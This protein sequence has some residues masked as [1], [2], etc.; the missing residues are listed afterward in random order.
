MVSLLLLTRFAARNER[1]SYIP[2]AILSAVAIAMLG[3]FVVG[4]QPSPVPSG[5]QRNPLVAFTQSVFSEN[6]SAS[7]ERLASK[8]EPDLHKEWPFGKVAG[9]ER[10]EGPST[11][12]RNVIVFAY[13][14]TPAKQSQGFG[15]VMPVTPNLL[16]SLS[17][18]LA[19]D[20]AYAHVPA[21][22]YFLVSAI[23]SA[24]PELS[25]V[26]TTYTHPDFDFNALPKVLNA[27]G[28]RTGFF[29]SSDNRFQN[30]D[31]FVRAAGF[32]TVKDYRDWVC[33]AGVYE[34]TSV[35]EKFLNTSSDL[36]TVE[37]ITDWIDQ[38]RDQ[39]FFV[40]FRT[41]MTHY[42]YFPGENPIDF[43]VEDEN[44]GNYL[45]ALR[46]GDQAFGELL[47]YLGEAGLMDETL[48]VVMGD[49]GEAFGEHGTYV[50]AA[51]IYEENVH[52]PLALINPQ[53]FDGAR[54]NLIVGLVD[55][56][57]TITDLMGLETPE[58]WQGNS[59]FAPSRPNGVMLFAPWNGFLIGYR[60]GDEKVIYNANSDEL[61]VY[62]L[63]ENP[64]ELV[65]LAPQSPNIKASKME[66]LAEMVATHRSYIDALL[67]GEKQTMVS[68]PTLETMTIAASGTYLQE[69]PKV[70]VK[71]D[72]VDVGGFTVTSA[73]SN[74]FREVP[75]EEI[76]AALE[77]FVLPLEQ[78]LNCPKRLEIYFLNDN[79]GG[80]GKT[81]DT[82]LW[83]RSVTIGGSVYHSTRFRE[84]KA[85]VGHNAGEYYRFSRSGGAYVDLYLDQHCLAE[86]LETEN[87]NP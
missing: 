34:F 39:P 13:E 4:H 63:R 24:I 82:D 33:E 30:T 53:L 78:E 42:P 68:R 46:V 17:N 32:E 49:H 70:W 5:K 57:P 43:G 26:S 52:I 18:G 8:V 9:L 55:V 11:K 60:E 87:P 79:W 85:R 22:N 58:T 77:K 64:G 2:K 69:R 16:A 6:E 29:N 20:R 73:I 38:D 25:S 27:A 61:E 19:F 81:G 21:S 44:Y 31:T 45:N 65:S 71:L 59:F 48:I 14:S 75:S 41:G 12:I 1:N 83:V 36:C 50:H 23:A 47:T 72:G 66:T 40:T 54:S 3:G 80:E 74:E 35:S 7:L 28:F 37:K 51:G 62:N 76:H 10:P 84:L 56:A 86:A 67:G 15:G